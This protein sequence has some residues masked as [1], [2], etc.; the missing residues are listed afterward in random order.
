MFKKLQ[1]T[2]TK[3]HVDVLRYATL[4]LS[5][6]ETI[7]PVLSALSALSLFTVMKKLMVTVIIICIIVLVFG[8]I[9]VGMIRDGHTKFADD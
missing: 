7:A 4:H 1:Y 2:I 6:T 5:K 8:E 3:F 9:E